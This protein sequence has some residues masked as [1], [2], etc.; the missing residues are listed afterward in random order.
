MS[1]NLIARLENKSSKEVEEIN[2]QIDDEDWI[3]LQK[4]KEYANQ[5]LDSKIIKQNIH[6]NIEIKGEN[7]GKIEF[8]ALLP[9]DDDLAVLFHRMRPFILQN[10]K[11]YFNRICNVI[12]KYFNHPIL[13]YV[14]QRHQDL[15]S[16]KDFQNTIRFKINDILINS[17]EFFN[18]WVNAFEYHKIDE[19]QNKINDIHG[20][21]IPFSNSKAII[22][23][24]LID[25]A[26]AVCEILKIIDSIEKKGNTEIHI[27]K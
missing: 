12:K 24:I 19:K 3:L 10:E 6:V 8:L 26:Q 2:V 22:I 11:T 23:A 17:E 4:F 25:K 16:C 18:T 20:S 9:P 1:H 15:F 7:E 13:R 14:I 5:L 27:P 21:L